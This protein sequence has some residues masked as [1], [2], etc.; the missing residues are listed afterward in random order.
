M[1]QGITIYEPSPFDDPQTWDYLTV[2]GIVW[3]SKVIIRRARRSYKW[4]VKNPAGQVGQN[5]TFR[6]NQYPAFELVFYFWDTDG[7]LKWQDFS[8]AFIIDAS[9]AGSPSSLA[10]GIYHPS[11]A[12]LGIS[13]IVVDDIGVA[14]RLSDGGEYS[15]TVT[16]REYKPV[17]TKNATAT[18]PGAKPATRTG[19]TTVDR[20]ESPDILEAR[21]ALADAM[22]RN[23]AA[24]GAQEQGPNGLPAQQ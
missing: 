24:N 7:W 4:D 10:V 16:V 3:S 1:T 12:V 15:A 21:A 18:P 14:E 6:G 20:P 13:A 8:K 17:T 11:L 2:G 9:K 22:A 5:Q 23:A 19:V